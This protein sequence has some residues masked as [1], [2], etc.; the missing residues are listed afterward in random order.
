MLLAALVMQTDRNTGN[1]ILKLYRKLS[2]R[3]YSAAGPKQPNRRRRGSNNGH[4]AHSK[5]LEGKSQLI[6]TSALGLK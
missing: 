3:G 6:A 4:S 5:A 1:E 2:A